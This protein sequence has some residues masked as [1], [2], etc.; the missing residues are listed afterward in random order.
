MKLSLDISESFKLSLTAIIANKSRGALTALGIIIGIVAVIITM[1]AANGLE[2]TFRQ[3]FASVG[4]DVIYVSKRP[5]VQMG[6]GFQFRNRRDISL[7][8][9]NSLEQRLLGKGIVNPSIGGRRNV[10]YQSKILDSIQIS[11]TT[12]KQIIVTDMVPEIGRFLM[13]FDV[14]YK[15]KVAVIGSG[16]AK[17]LFEN[18]NALGKVFNIGRYKF[19]VIGVMEEQGSSFFGGPNFDKVI[20]I[21]ITTF[22]KTIGSSGGRANVNIAIKA[23]SAEEMADFEYEVIG[24]MRKI[25]GLKPIEADDFSINKLDTLLDA[26]NNMMGVVVLVGLIITGISLFVGGVGVMNIMFVSVTERTREIGIRKAI[27]AKKRSILMQFLFES[28]TICLF[29]GIVGLIIAGLITKIINEM[30]MPASLSIS[31]IITALIISVLVGVIS[32]FVPALRGARLNPID[33]LHYE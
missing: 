3:T 28:A 16:I 18:T 23:P 17:G 7:A 13:P 24:E 30:L 32:G 4:A 29:G 14:E 19:T 9:S 6:S 33:A 5:W 15:K 2:N 31:I 22:G 1:T 11:G 12:D 27:G 21:P 8:A 10:K 20:Y 26:Y 25:R